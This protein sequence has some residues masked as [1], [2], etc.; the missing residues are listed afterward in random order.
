MVRND[1]DGTEEG[2]LDMD[3]LQDLT[4]YACQNYAR[5]RTRIDIPTAIR[6]ADL[7]ASRTQ[8]LL[9]EEMKEMTVSPDKIL[10]SPHS[11]IRQLDGKV[12]Q[13]RGVKSRLYFC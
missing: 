8:L 12:Q 10:K 9:K 4:F 3:Q 7:C 1:S 6:Y 2:S 5:S 13:E 11:I